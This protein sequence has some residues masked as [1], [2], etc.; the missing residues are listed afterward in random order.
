MEQSANYIVRVVLSKPAY[1]CLTC[2]LL[3]TGPVK[4]SVRDMAFTVQWQMDSPSAGSVT[5]SMPVSRHHRQ[6]WSLTSQPSRQGQAVPSTGQL[7]QIIG[8]ELQHQCVCHSRDKSPSL[9]RQLRSLITA[10]AA[11]LQHIQVRLALRPTHIKVSDRSGCCLTGNT[12]LYV[13]THAQSLTW[14]HPGFEWH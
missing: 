3:P 8:S 2:L 12:V 13:H 14:H 10:A 1:A 9:E 5:S 11:G 7:A 4:A 6:A